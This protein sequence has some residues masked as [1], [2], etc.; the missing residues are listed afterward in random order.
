M[1]KLVY[2]LSAFAAAVLIP[3]CTN[4]SN[5]HNEHEQHEH[6]HSHGDHN[7]GDHD[8]EGH[9]HEGHDHSHGHE[10]HDHE[11]EEHEEGVI[12]LEPERAEKLGVDVEVINPGMFKEVLKVSGQ[13][14][15]SPSDRGVVTAK[16]SGILTFAP[17]I[18]EG[19]KVSVG[20]RIASVSAKGIAGGDPNEAAKT[21]LQAAKRE[22][23]RVTPLAEEGIVSKKDYN[24]ALQTYEQAKAAYSGSASGSVATAT[25]NGIIT[26][27]LVKQGEYVEAG[28]PIAEISGAGKL[29]LRADVPEKK[30][31]FVSSLTSANF[32]INSSDN[33]FSLDALGGKR[34]AEGSIS[35]AASGYIPVYFN[36]SNNGQVIPGSYA[37]VYLLGSEREGVVSV[38]VASLY[39]Q[40]GQ[41]FI[42]IRLDE[43][44][45]EKRP[46][47]LGGNNGERVEI[48]SGLNP[49]ETVVTKG[50]TFVRLSENAGAVPE[51]HSHSH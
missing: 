23:D 3:A 19:S 21:A 10:G 32:R 34:V 20:S 6:S 16:S 7:H 40:Q 14:I 50:V 51:G 4:N 25:A 41:K 31:P 33:V 26:A 2:I 8:H 46:V 37:E 44:C 39:E 47:T 27:M 1:K 36:F 9:S 38:P 18:T 49:G 22:L 45:Y 28:T 13:V 15:P 35:A 24:A 12:T 30:Y 29:T 43:D 42:F 11:G 17:G 5:A 48:L